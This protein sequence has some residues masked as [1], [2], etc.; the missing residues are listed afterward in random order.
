MV[1]NRTKQ[2]RCPVGQRRSAPHTQ[3]SP[4]TDYRRR[5]GALGSTGNV[6]RIHT[7]RRGRFRSER[8]T[9]MRFAR[10]IQELTVAGALEAPP[11]PPSAPRATCPCS[12]QTL[13]NPTLPTLKNYA[14]TPLHFS[15]ISGVF[16]DWAT[17]RRDHVPDFANDPDRLASGGT[18]G[19]FCARAVE[20]PS[21][22][23]AC[24]E[25]VTGV[26]RKCCASCRALTHSDATRNAE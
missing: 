12:D 24:A 4:S 20:D 14:S 17:A 25:G 18:L 6:A 26:S 2:S 19:D 9:L 3:Y 23:P 21:K 1:L 16:H 11:S 5:G 8:R 13:L 15:A 7:K 22:N 10:T